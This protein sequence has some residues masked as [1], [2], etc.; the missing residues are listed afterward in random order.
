[1]EQRINYQLCQRDCS[2]DLRCFIFEKTIK[3][4]FEYSGKPITPHKDLAI[5]DGFLNT[6]QRVLKGI[7]KTLS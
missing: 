2:Y 6:L 3:N 7:D 4:L 5:Q 1:M